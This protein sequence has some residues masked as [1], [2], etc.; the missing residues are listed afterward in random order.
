[1]AEAKKKATRTTARKATVRTTAK[2][3]AARTTKRTTA[4]RAEDRR[5]PATKRP[6]AAK[7]T[8]TK[9]SA[10]AK[11]TIK[12][13]TSVQ[14]DHAVQR[15]RTESRLKQFLQAFWQSLIEPLTPGPRPDA[16]AR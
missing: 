11:S 6:A 14:A 5:A 13:S 2:K 4:V 15:K 1:M 10:A 16:F 8:T 7:K 9:R 12:R 3:P